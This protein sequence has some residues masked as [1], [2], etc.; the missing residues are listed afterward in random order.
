MY[1]CAGRGD[2]G[3]Q[4]LSWVLGQ[5]TGEDPNPAL[6]RDEPLDQTSY[7]ALV[8]FAMSGAPDS[9]LSGGAVALRGAEAT[10]TEH[11]RATD[12]SFARQHFTGTKHEVPLLEALDALAR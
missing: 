7:G 1:A 5:L 3:A 6:P 10:G 2:D 12:L 11:E 4:L 9:P 8:D